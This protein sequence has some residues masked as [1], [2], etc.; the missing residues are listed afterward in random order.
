MIRAGSGLSSTL[1]RSVLL[2]FAFPL[3]CASVPIIMDIAVESGVLEIVDRPSNY[4]PGIMSEIRYESRSPYSINVRTRADTRPS[5][6]FALCSWRLEYSSTATAPYTFMVFSRLRLMGSNLVP[7]HELDYHFGFRIGTPGT[8]YTL[9]FICKTDWY[10]N[11]ATNY[12]YG[13]QTDLVAYGSSQTT[14]ASYELPDAA[15]SISWVD[16]P[17]QPGGDHLSIIVRWGSES[18]ALPAMGITDW[19]PRQFLHSDT[20]Y[21]SGRI[22]T[23]DRTYIFAIANNRTTA[24]RWVGSNA[25]YDRGT[26]TSASFQFFWDGFPW[27]AETVHIDFYPITDHGTIGSAERYYITFSD[28]KFHASI[29]PPSPPDDDDDDG[30]PILLIVGGAAGLFVVFL[31]LAICVRCCNSKKKKEPVGNETPAAATPQPANPQGYP[32]QGYPPGYPPQGYALTAPQ[33]YPSHQWYPPQ[34][35]WPPGQ[36]QGNPAGYQQGYP[37]QHGGPPGQTQGNPA[38]PEGAS[39][40]LAPQ[41]QPPAPAA[42]D[43]PSI[44][45][46]FAFELEPV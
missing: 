46:M 41:G 22:E 12:W 27:G 39:R 45:D 43:I 37:P 26:F 33:G 14:A 40:D 35:G 8:I 20:I 25:G 23:V 32:P 31:L 30:P 15:F 17:P 29:H 3:A 21:I 13:A 4:P 38:P 10:V 44:D 28:G 11:P 2:A 36:P 42:S 9:D 16:R 7:C 1:G 19:S 34:Q 5:G 24:V 6:A 18:T